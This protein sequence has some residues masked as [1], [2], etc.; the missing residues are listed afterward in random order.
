MR[1][2]TRIV[3][4]LAGFAD[5][6]LDR[7]TA[8]A[9]IFLDRRWFRLLETQDLA[10]LC[11]GE[12]SLRYVIASADDGLVALCPFLVTRSQSITYVYSLEKLFFTSWPAQLERMNPASASWSRRIGQLTEGYRRLMRALGAGSEGWVLATSPLSFRGGVACQEL[13]AAE[14]QEVDDVIL[15]TLQDVARTERLPLCVNS[16]AEASPLREA[17]ARRGFAEVFYMFDNGLDLEGPRFDD[18]LGRFK[19]EVRK[20]FKYEMRGVEKRGYRFEVRRDYAALAPEIA[21]SYSATYSKYGDDHFLHPARFWV[22]LE[23]ALGANAEAVV[24]FHG[25]TPAGFCMLLHK[26]E[27]MFTYRVGRFPGP[28]GN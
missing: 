13:P 6:E 25:D 20:S 3:D 1:Y 7:V 2:R 23:R 27:E 21:A 5:A 14:R 8:G 11:R 22:D 4:S 10:G 26:A 12:L 9:S 15:A 18:Y 17:L 16:I 24:A 28:D 19:G